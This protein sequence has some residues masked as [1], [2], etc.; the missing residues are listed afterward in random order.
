VILL[1]IN[2]SC[3]ADTTV[4]GTEAVTTKQ[5]DLVSYAPVVEPKI[6]SDHTN[7]ITALT[8]AVVESA[9]PRGAR[10]RQTTHV[11][12]KIY[13]HDGTREEEFHHNLDKDALAA[14][15]QGLGGEQ[16][17]LVDRQMRKHRWVHASVPESGSR[18][19]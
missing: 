16:E 10:T 1:T 6:S 19:L 18:G 12:R 3:L 15:A 9:I 4:L 2:V 5:A 7:A 14:D 11:T 17:I 13:H 8:C